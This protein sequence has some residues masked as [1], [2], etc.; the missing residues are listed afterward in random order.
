[1]FI[2]WTPLP[3]LIGWFLSKEGWRALLSLVMYGF[4]SNKVLYSASLSFTMFTGPAAIAQWVPQNRV[5]PFFLL[6]GYLLG[7]RSLVF[8]PNFGK[9]LENHMKW[10]MTKPEFF[11]KNFFSSI[12][13]KMVH[14]F[15]LNSL[16]KLV[17]NFHWICSIIKTYIICCVSVHNVYLVEILFLGYEPKCS[18]P[19]RL[20]YLQKN[21]N[22]QNKWMK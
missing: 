6:S 11:R 5:F 10:S 3:L 19:I 22:L 20:Q 1:M 14:K 16:E 15:F 4:C 8:F 17:F 2:V 18:L 21:K 12:T 13:G 7:I 9:V